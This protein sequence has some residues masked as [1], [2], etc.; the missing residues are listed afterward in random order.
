MHLKGG[1]IASTAP[2]EQN[3]LTTGS[4]TWENIQNQSSYSASAASLSGSYG[5]NSPSQNPDNAAFRE[6]ALGQAFANSASSS[7]PG[8]T[9]GLPAH[10]SGGDGSTT[11][12]TIS[13][14]RLNIGGK[15]TS[16]EEVGIHSNPESAHR[17]IKA[18]PD[19]PQL[20]QNQQTVAA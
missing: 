4:L 17:Q 16:V 6:S 9:P 8:F 11:Y 20:M 18:L 1:A 5:S 3:A 12:A 13:A 10:G 14:G 7:S 19:L 15:D 2:A